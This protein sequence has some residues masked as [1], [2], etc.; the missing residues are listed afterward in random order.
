MM[1]LWFNALCKSRGRMGMV[2]PPPT[3]WSFTSSH[4]WLS[5]GR[6]RHYEAKWRPE[7]GWV[8]VQ[9]FDL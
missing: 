3:P 9:V 6:Q 4:E 5:D 7:D 1:D 8:C 2:A